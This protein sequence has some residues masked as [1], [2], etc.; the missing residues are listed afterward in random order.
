MKRSKLS[1]TTQYV[2]LFGVLM[3]TANI[4]LGMVLMAQSSS[5]IQSLV[6]EN[7]LNISNTAAGLLDGDALGALTADDVGSPAYNDILRELSVFQKNV[8]IEYIYTV[9]QTG[10][11]T[12]VFTVDA[13]PDDP[14]DFGE[15]VLVTP[16]LVTAASGTAAVDDAPA[17]D[18]WGNYYSSYS[19]VFDADGHVAGIVGVDFS[20]E[21]FDAQIKSYLLS[22]GVI[23]GL[24]ILVGV[25]AVLLISGKV[26]QRLKELEGELSV[27]SGDLEELTA[28][29][30]GDAEAVGEASPDPDRAEISVPGRDSDEIE[31]LNERMRTMQREL[32]RYLDY[33]HAQANTDALTGVGNTTA[34]TDAQA[35]LDER[36]R[37]GTADFSV[38]VFDIND[39]KPVNDRHGHLCGNRIIQGAANAIESA[40][41]R[42]MTFRIGGDEF[43]VIAEDC[44]APEMDAMLAHIGAQIDEFNR[45]ETEEDIRLSVSTG[46]AVYRP[47]R[48]ASFRD[49]FNRADSSMYENKRRYHY[50]REGIRPT[51]RATNR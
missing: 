46:S 4:I 25:I 12:F 14:A 1:L 31:S 26:R 42:D 32:R 51:V 13:D 6:R 37:A 48:D 28:Q 11:G 39:L 29:F 43:A 33:V 45:R 23:T 50:G 2:V 47:G 15:A 3:L 44:A 27:L 20:S 17:E 30:H 40:C 9:R 10:E 18:E 19:P 36:I 24:S 49:V 38:A 34:Y 5:M 22:T 16:A 7:M 21:W 41:G 35:R 8:D